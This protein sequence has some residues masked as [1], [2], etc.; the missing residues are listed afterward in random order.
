MS[1]KAEFYYIVK[2]AT[3]LALANNYSSESILYLYISYTDTIPRQDLSS[4]C[5]SIYCGLV[6]RVPGYRSRGP[7]LDSWPYQIF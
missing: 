6:V 4:Y 3:I 1:R 2:Y 5:F 7:G